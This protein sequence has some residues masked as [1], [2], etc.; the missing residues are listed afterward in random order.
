MAPPDQDLDI[1]TELEDALARL[2]GS[3]EAQT[4]QPQ[5]QRSNIVSLSVPPPPPAKEAPT[6]PGM[7][8]TQT[9]LGLSLVRP[10]S[11]PAKEPAQTQ[12]QTQTQTTAATNVTTLEP[13]HPPPT[14]EL[15]KRPPP[16]QFGSRPGT[17][18]SDRSV[19]PQKPPQLL[20][21]RA[22]LSMNPLTRPSTANTE[23]SVSLA[24]AP[25]RIVGS[26]KRLSWS[27][28]STT[29]R[30]IKYGKGKFSHVELVPQPSDDPEDPL[31]SL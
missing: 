10:P 23:S 2:A 18:G 29:R 22:P 28:I 16:L 17:S 21:L 26:T 5:Q 31:V 15:P 30:P 6:A 24:D 1:K 14:R 9:K 8:T 25:K 19:M 13:P 27:S 4:A 3:D 12:T 20:S 7:A 11:P